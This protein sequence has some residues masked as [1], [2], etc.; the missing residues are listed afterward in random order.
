MQ[1]LATL[2]FALTLLGAT[3]RAEILVATVGPIKGQ[4]AALGQQLERGAR[5]AINDINAAGGVNGEQ[6]S[7]VAE[8]DNCDPKQAIEVARQ[9]VSRG[10][11]VVA[12]HYC[13]GSSIAAAK[14]YEG[15]GILMISPSSTSPKL[16]DE[17]GWNVHRVCGRDDA[18]GAFA[19]RAIAKLFAGKKVAI[20]DDGSIPGAGLAAMFKAALNQGGL[21][22]TLRETYK[23][24]QNDYDE[25]VQRLLSANVDVI[26]VGGF[27]N[28][29]GTIIRQMRELASSA[30]MVGGDALLVDQYW[31]VAGTT[32]DGTL[33]TF[34]EDA[35]KLASAKSIVAEFQAAGYNPEGYTIHA[36]A[37]VQA[38]AQAATA[39]KSLDGK[40]LGQWLRAGNTLNT[41]LGSISMDAKGDV[42]DARFAWYK[43]SQ[44]KFAETQPLSQ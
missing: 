27:A 13:S 28:E 20:L 16:T 14:I 10:V 11:K 37:A 44:G 3:A 17:G 43:W 12:G 32:G 5:Q 25:L 42:K 18:Q 36:Y 35:Q 34:A 21:A 41:V 38:F 1:L 7:L 26:Y 40:T 31:S 8:D 23:P 4:Y 2:F 22:E 6:L 24:G 15:A 9:L 29:A 19:G 33:A 30:I 39:T